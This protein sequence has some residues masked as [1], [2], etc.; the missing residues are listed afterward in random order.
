LEIDPAKNMKVG[1]QEDGGRDIRQ[2]TEFN[3]LKTRGSEEMNEGGFQIRRKC[4]PHIPRST[5]VNG[6]AC[7]PRRTRGKVGSDNIHDSCLPSPCRINDKMLNV[8]TNCV[9]WT[10]IDYGSVELYSGFSK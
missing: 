4:M 5:T 6:V 7:G 10:P 1:I 8:A 9:D 3:S 2:C